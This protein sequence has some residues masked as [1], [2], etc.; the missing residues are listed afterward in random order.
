MELY[1]LRSFIAVA[2]EGRLTVAAK[3]LNTSQPALSTQIK[4]LEDEIGVS[5][6]IRTPKG[7]K[8]STEGSFLK[9]YA[10][11][12]L[13]EADQFIKKAG[14][15]KENIS[16]TA[17]IGLNTDSQRL[18]INELINTIRQNYLNINFEILKSNSR[19][20]LK[21][22]ID[23]DIDFAYVYG[24]TNSKKVE[25][26]PLKNCKLVVA[27]PIDWK[28][29]M[30][31]ANWDELVKLPWIFASGRCPF[32]IQAFKIFNEKKLAQSKI[33]ITDEDST[34]INLVSSGI[35]LSLLVE[36]ALTD[37]NKKFYIWDRECFH[38]NLKFCYLK[39]RKKESI[40]QVV[41]AS[42]AEIWQAC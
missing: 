22:L 14:Y 20:N 10:E 19:Q 1:Q 34:I 9:S 36:E 23:G 30:Q 38:T 4:K 17:K 41:L 7:M 12:C 31:N 27:G 15:L 11:K 35:G 25:S 3:K 39:Q 26:I 8:L 37:S 16:G 24:E 29:K 6:F 18:K 21:Q 13:I 40:F 33:T 5:L 32:Y 28:Q 42:I 2:D